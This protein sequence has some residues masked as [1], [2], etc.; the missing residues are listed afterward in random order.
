MEHPEVVGTIEIAKRLK[1]SR[2]TVDQWRQ[3]QLGFPAPHWEVG[4]RPAWRWKDVERW[5]IDSGRL[6]R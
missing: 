6:Q 4:G 2:G 3:R 1:V 5:A